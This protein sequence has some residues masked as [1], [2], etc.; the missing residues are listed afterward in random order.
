MSDFDNVNGNM[1]GDV[2]DNVND[3]VPEPEEPKKRNY[4]RYLEGNPYGD[5]QPQPQTLPEQ[6]PFMPGGF[7]GP[8]FEENIPQGNEF[9]SLGGIPAPDASVSSEYLM[10]GGG[11]APG[12]EPQS[13]YQ[14]G[15]QYDGFRDGGYP[16]G[17]LNNPPQIEGLE[18]PVSMGE[19]L[20]CFLLMMVPCVN[21]IMM[22]VWAFSKTE[23]KSKS[24]FFKAELILMG[25]VFALYIVVIIIVAVAGIGMATAFR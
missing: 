16:G 13:P 24:N 25:I 8:A 22:F 5:G 18:E 1:N 19:W 15:P 4:E 21:I 3:N 11:V 20:I 10:P 12:N 9:A 14:G 7:E 23:K 17:G 6:D 2:F